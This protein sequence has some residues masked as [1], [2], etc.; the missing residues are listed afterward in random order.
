VTAG[1]RVAA[2]RGQGV[3]LFLDA[4]QLR[5]RAVPGTLTPAL[6]AEISGHKAELIGALEAELRE[7]MARHGLARCSRCRRILRLKELGPARET[8]EWWCRDWADCRGAIP[9]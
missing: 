5:C 2:L 4:D 8:G 9:H 1:E 7:E 3:T 6:K